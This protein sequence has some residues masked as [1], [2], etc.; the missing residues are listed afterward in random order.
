MLQF[1]P[2][3]LDSFPIIALRTIF[4]LNNTDALS[5]TMATDR[6]KVLIPIAAAGSNRPR[7]NLLIPELPPLILPELPSSSVSRTLSGSPFPPSPY[8][9]GG[10]QRYDTKMEQNGMI[11]IPSDDESDEL[12]LDSLWKRSWDKFKPKSGASTGMAWN[13]RRDW[14]IGC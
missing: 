3:F 7:L 9:A 2:Y 13:P 10:L 1:S 11:E 8:N 12:S 6:Q 5:N 14:S 4:Q